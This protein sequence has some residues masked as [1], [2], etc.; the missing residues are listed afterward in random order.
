[1]LGSP[2]T[3]VAG[4][5]L[6]ICVNR[7]PTVGSA[8]AKVKPAFAATVY[9]GTEHILVEPGPSA[10]GANAKAAGRRCESARKELVCSGLCRSTQNISSAA[11]WL[12]GQ[13]VFFIVKEEEGL[14]FS[15]EQLG[16]RDRAPDLETRLIKNDR[17]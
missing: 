16:N 17:R 3:L 11:A 9:K 1:M 2:V 5:E 12:L 8:F 10:S 4:T 14:V 7:A 15:I 13:A 6:R